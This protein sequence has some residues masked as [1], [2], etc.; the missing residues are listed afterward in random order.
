MDETSGTDWLLFLL[1][2]NSDSH[3]SYSILFLGPSCSTAH[4]IQS[5][6]DKPHIFRLMRL[7]NTKT[8][9][10]AEFFVN[11]PSYA[12]LSHTWGKEEVMF[13][14]IQNLETAKR[15]AGYSKVENACKRAR[16]YE[17][18]WIW[19]DSCCINKESSAELSEAINSMYQYYQDAVVCYAYLADVFIEDHS[20]LPSL[21]LENSKWFKRGWTLQELIAPN[22][23]VFLDADWTR[24]GTRWSLRDAISAITS[25][26]V[27]IFEGHNIDDYS[28]AQ[29]MSWA[30]FRET[31]RP[32]DR[33]YCLMGVFGVSS[34]VRAGLGLK[35][36]ARAGLCRARAHQKSKP[37]PKPSVGSGLGRLG[38]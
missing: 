18:E 5:D 37:G 38:L 21:E 29:R 10:L 20:Q 36:R 14:D 35:A 33:A 30:A 11:I 9:T 31:T 17:F 27:K 32:E 23:V 8:L 24:I 25:I 3:I 15:K 7:L 28:V 4:H 19:I 26:P 12:I 22:Y 34:D 6:S 2:I 1:L 16:Q 13:Q